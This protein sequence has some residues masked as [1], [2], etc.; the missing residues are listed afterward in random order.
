ML[1]F[2][3]FLVIRRT[4]WLKWPFRAFL[5]AELAYHVYTQKRENQ[6]SKMGENMKIT[7][8]IGTQ[9][10]NNRF[11]SCVIEQ[12]F[13]PDEIIYQEASQPIAF[14]RKSRNSTSN[15]PFL[16]QESWELIPKDIIG[17]LLN[18][19]V[20][21]TTKRT[22][23]GE[24][25]F[26]DNIEDTCIGHA[27]EGSLVFSINPEE[28]ILGLGQ[29]ED[30]VSNYR[31]CTQHLYQN[32]MQIPMPV[33]LSTGGYA[34][35]LD[36][37]CLMVYEEY[38]NRITI[39]FDAIEQICYYV[40]EGD[41]LGE[42]VSG[43]RRLTGKAPLLPMW[44]YGYVQ[45]KE[46]YHRQ[47]ELLEV[48]AEFAKREIH[49]SCL[50]QDW[51][52]WEEGKWGDKHLDKV[53]YPDLK[54]ATDKLHDMGIGV[55][56]SVW[57]NMTQGSID[58]KEML[59]AGKLLADLST[60]N[61]FDEEARELY[62]QQCAREIFKGGIDAWWCDSTEPFTPDWNGS[63]K[64]EA[65]ERFL[66][67]KEVLTK[68]MDARKANT[69]ALYHA[70]G[71]YE[72]QRKEDMTKRVVNLTRSGY[73]SI[74][75]Y[76]AVLW[77]GDIMAT[78]EVLKKQIVEGLQMS[79]SGI[80]YWT[81]DIGAFF[82]GNRKAWMRGNGL[83]EGVQPWF[84]NGDYDDGV[85]D[86]GYCELYVRWLQYGTF[87]PIM[88]SHGTDTPREPW[89]FG[90]SQTVYYDT[91]VKYIRMR[92]RLVPYI[93][94]LAYQVYRNDAM[95]M[96]GLIFDYP[97]DKRAAE[98]HDQ[99]LFGDFLV[100]PVTHPVEYG[101]NNTLVD[102]VP[103]RQ[104]YLPKNDIWYDYETGECFQGNQDVLADAPVEKMPLYI[105]G[106]SILPVTTESKINLYTAQH[107]E[108][109]TIEI[110]SGK[111][112]EFTYYVD[113]GNGY[114]YQDG[115]Y[116]AITLTWSDLDRILTIADVEGSYA[117]PKYWELQ[118]IA[119]DGNRTVRQIA[120]QGKLIRVEL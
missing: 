54:Q 39:H 33:F 1:F 78:W 67:A 119:A 95:L 10:K 31:N 90:E 30:G 14:M 84:W 93:Y 17:H 56:F 55:M 87:L 76:G 35:L 46:R 115:E 82:A 3:R 117:Y 22:V 108:K 25:T 43:I 103:K 63:G 71:I 105:R 37:G 40:I 65:A 27:Y 120:Y 13:I 24:R 112:G 99:Y 21:V 5:I 59:D 47:K 86:K 53:R 75:K 73:P 68:F 113:R 50:V 28:R 64:K 34:V 38:D 11:N 114:G 110:F 4:R 51:Q 94:S 6:K 45:S 44:A 104:V 91:I 32:N 79:S 52:T 36:A 101:P 100:C 19:K 60:Y 107:P 9:N 111:D 2:G 18:E 15:D 81:L 58:N 88:R 85:A 20:E 57:P 49:V 16:R 116:A 92:Y 29:H 106:G 23:D 102:G 70:K 80:P 42:L 62:W 98:I 26:V 89:N 77:S 96:R 72:H 8:V 83:K 61:A 48:A 109:I 97:D 66:L 41:T 118:L 74:Q 69:Y 12:D 7:K